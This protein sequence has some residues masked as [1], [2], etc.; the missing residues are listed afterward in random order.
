[1]GY[2]CFPRRDKDKRMQRREKNPSMEQ[3]MIK[4]RVKKGAHLQC[5]QYLAE[6]GKAWLELIPAKD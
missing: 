2:L 4:K 3:K 5:I 6:L 1:M